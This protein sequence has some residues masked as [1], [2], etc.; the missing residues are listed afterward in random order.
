[1][2]VAQVPGG[3]EPGLRQALVLPQHPVGLGKLVQALLRRDAGEVADPEDAVAL[4]PRALVAVGVD[5]ERH[6]GDLVERDA[7][8]LGACA[9]RRTR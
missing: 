4:G 7:E 9:P 8:E 6:D 5:A 2:L 3:L 1:M